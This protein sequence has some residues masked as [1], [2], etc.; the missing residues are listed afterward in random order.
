MDKKVIHKLIDKLAGQFPNRTAIEVKENIYTYKELI[1]KSDKISAIVKG[2]I[3]PGEVVGVFLESGFEYVATILGINKA[4]GVF[5]PLDQSY[6]RYRL[7]Y[8]LDKANPSLIIT[9]EASVQYIKALL[10]EI[11][12][13]TFVSL[14]LLLLEKEKDGGGFKKV[15]VTKTSSSEDKLA[16]QMSAY[17]ACDVNGEDS[18]YLIFTSGSTGTPKAI[19][20]RHKSL[21]HFIHWETNEFALDSSVRVSQLA[22]LSFD[23]SLRDIFVPLL[24]GGT[25]V[26]P[27][28]ELKQR[29]DKLLRWIADKDIQ[30]VHTVPSMFRFFIKTLQAEP[31][32]KEELLNLKR[33]FL[34][35]EPLFYKD[36]SA[37][38]DIMGGDIELINLYGPSE[39]TLAK[40]FHRISPFDQK[41][42]IVPLGQP[43]S[44]TVVIIL[45]N[46]K[47]CEIGEIGEI[48]I[49]TPFRTKGYYQDDNLNAH[50]FIQNPLHN[51]Y[52]DI[53]YKTGDL[54]RYGAN[55]IIE[56]IG[57]RDGQIKIRGNRVELAEIES[58]I[59]QMDGVSQVV[60]SIVNVTEGDPRICCY[61]LKDDNLEVADFKKHIDNYLPDYMKPSFYVEMAQFPL[62]I[63]GK[64]NRQALPR[65]EELLYEKYAYETPES[66][67]EKTIAAIWGE[68]LQLSKVSVN[69]SFFELGGHSLNATKVITELYKQFGVE[70]TLKDFFKS[71]TVRELA[72]LVS[73]AEKTDYSE[74]LPI[75]IQDD[76]QLS[77]QQHRLWVH[78]QMDEKGESIYSINL[79][80]R[81]HGDIKITQLEQA[82]ISVI[83]RHEILRTSFV[84]KEGTPRQKVN[85]TNALAFA[86]KMKAPVSENLDENIKTF[87]QEESSKGFELEEGPLLRVSLLTLSKSDFVLSISVHHIISDA[88]SLKNLF[89]EV[90]MAYE[91]NQVS[92][93][94]HPLKFQY[95]DFTYWQADQLMKHAKQHKDYWC[96]L[97]KNI[98][99]LDL[100]TEYNRPAFRSF[101][102]KTITY[103]FESS[104][105]GAL[106]DGCEATE[107][108]MFMI[109]LSAV[110]ILLYRYTNQNDI[111]VGSPFAGREHPDLKNQIGFY[112]NVLPIYSH[113][114]S[115]DL[116]IDV[117]EQVKARVL[118][119]N[120]HQIY[121]F[122]LLVKDLNIKRI[123]GRAPLFDVRV[124]LHNKTNFTETLTDIEI[125]QLF[126]EEKVSQY[127]LTFRFAEVDQEVLLSLNYAT[128]LFSEKYIKD[129]ISRFELLLKEITND[130]YM[131]VGDLNLDQ[132]VDSSSQEELT[133]SFNFD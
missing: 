45:K 65:P 115:E 12:K 52:E 57:R 74:I 46:N 18:N 48:H 11:W 63:N 5:M 24:N 27:D 61:F 95:K 101:L 50:S 44:N 88:W 77:H 127:D 113:I 125:E 126:E 92:A 119:A 34:A 123:A 36:V 108:S 29:P 105:I 132:H 128:E 84:K 43:I 17:S 7:Q 8:I 3:N 13:D 69:H 116:I 96:Q 98:E 23:V 103:K 20:G 83:E 40:V 76:Y 89:E 100:P 90:I 35:G 21:S 70:V 64:I 102:G 28:V 4:A 56:Y 58:V 75:E 110:D 26:I 68:I 122:D 81:L 41:E 25:L 16:L 120:D 6:P 54:G 86:I 2:I 118:E 14:D 19:E 73:G 38:F 31:H 22:P 60:I 99:A 91:N 66:D 121:P 47:I 53:I 80:Y 55:R 10:S 1:E 124:E 104:T 72:I 129:L 133:T 59:G 87:L 39:T 94:D 49:K 67:F 130:L 15:S 112:V 79:Y 106:K 32:L 85:G 71:P 9:N 97:L 42:G 78:E 93:K 131:Q 117:I 109:L 114:T 82:F 33:I 62:N 51:D 111:I 107:V 37:W 30:L